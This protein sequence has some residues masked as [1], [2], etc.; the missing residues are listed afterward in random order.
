MDNN[1]NNDAKDSIDL[2][3]KKEDSSKLVSKLQDC[4]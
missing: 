1:E 4:R 2:V 3:D